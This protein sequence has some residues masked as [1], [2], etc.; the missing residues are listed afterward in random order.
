MRIA[1]DAFRK[2]NFIEKNSQVSRVVFPKIKPP[3]TMTIFNHLEV[4][5][6]NVMAALKRR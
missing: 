3:L 2:A 6:N 4:L 5:E 1:Y